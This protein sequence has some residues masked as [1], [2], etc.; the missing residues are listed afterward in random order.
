MKSHVLIVVQSERVHEIDDM[1]SCGD[2]HICK[3]IS[4]EYRYKED[5]NVH[6]AVMAVQFLFTTVRCLFRGLYDFIGNLQKY[7]HFL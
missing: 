2:I 4:G 3:S 6:F 1:K 5:S 7:L